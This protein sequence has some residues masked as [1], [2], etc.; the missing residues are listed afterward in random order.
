MKA[1]L[2]FT[3]KELLESVRTY[4]LL[5]LALV[6]LLLGMLGPLSAKLTPQ[7]MESLMSQGIQITMPEPT[8]FDS[9]TQFF[10]NVSQM[11]FMVLAIMFSGV[12]TN[13]FSRGTLINILTKGLPRST[14]I[15]SKFT[16][17]SGIWTVSY[18]FCFILSYLYTAYFWRSGVVSNLLFSAFC[19]WLF[20][21]ML[22][23]VIMLGGVISRNRYGCLLSTGGF[24]VILTLLNMVGK[25]QNYN[26]LILASNNMDLLTGA[27]A[28]KDW[29]ESIIISFIMIILSLFAAIKI[30]NKKQ[31]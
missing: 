15:L 21:V 13:E 10:K 16:V 24:A 28:P 11:G 25:I 26:P 17:A 27:A 23:A 3:R 20:G 6:F 2:A 1:Y 19:L 4:K 30:F 12:M 8:A 18:A 9:W 7:L 31:L 5:I 14:V 22:I 29:W